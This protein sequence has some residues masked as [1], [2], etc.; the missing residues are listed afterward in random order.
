MAAI[1]PN[2]VFLHVPKTGGSWCR[3]AILASGLQYFESGPR[4]ELHT[5][6][7]AATNVFSK[8]NQLHDTAEYGFPTF[9]IKDWHREDRTPHHRMVFGFVRHPLAWLASPRS[10]RC[11]ARRR[12]GWRGPP[13]RDDSGR[14]ARG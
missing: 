5:V 8:I 3:K 12:S 9:H 11:Q 2:S 10:D 1:L 13:R 14:A 4:N 7:D 6:E